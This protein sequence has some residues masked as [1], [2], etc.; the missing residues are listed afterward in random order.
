VKRDLGL[1]CGCYIADTELSVVLDAGSAILIAGLAMKGLDE[2]WVVS[3]HVSYGDDGVSFR[4]LG[5]LFEGNTDDVAVV[6]VL[7][8][9]VVKARFLKVSVVQYFLWPSFRAAFIEALNTTSCPRLVHMVL[10]NSTPCTYACRP[11]TYGVNCAPRPAKS[12]KAP[13]AVRFGVQR[14]KPKF[15]PSRLHCFNGTDWVLEVASWRGTDISIQTD[16]GPWM[17]WSKKQWKESPEWLL[18]PFPVATRVRVR[19]LW[20]GTYIAEFHAT[21][22]M[23]HDLTTSLKTS[24]TLQIRSTWGMGG[25]GSAGDSQSVCSG[26][27]NRPA[28]FLGASFQAFQ[29]L[30]E[31]DTWG[32]QA[33]ASL[34][35]DRLFESIYSCSNVS[36]GIQ[37]LHRNTE[38]EGV[39][40]HVGGFL[41]EQCASRATIVVPQVSRAQLWHVAVVFVFEET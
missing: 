18:L 19:A 17:A 2:A 28:L 10:V 32:Q 11:T 30:N 23:K 25:F 15:I 6:D 3:F 38:L 31:A 37:W 41:V 5:G 9:Y 26:V 36:D 22:A 4:P 27:A 1:E 16:G 34:F 8:P 24:P 21:V 7:F 20:N 33:A 13:G 29:T 39:Q 40:A 14:T 35:Q 12:Q